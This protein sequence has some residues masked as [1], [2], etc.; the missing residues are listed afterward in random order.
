[1]RC[2]A[3]ALP[4]QFGVQREHASVWHQRVLRIGSIEL[5]AHAAH[6]YRDRR[7]GLRVK[8]ARVH[9][10]ADTFDAKDTR[11]LYRRRVAPS[12]KPLRPIQS[13]CSDPY[14]GPAATRCRNGY[15]LQAKLFRPP[16]FTN[17]PCFQDISR[18]DLSPTFEALRV[19]R[20]NICRITSPMSGG[21]GGRS[22]HAKAVSMGRS[23]C[24]CD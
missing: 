4:W 20:G 18:V 7:S 23:G 2:Y 8:A 19:P 9:D 24:V 5:A 16:R 13:E 1:M 10:F 6:D 17:N 15:V 14:Q 22:P 11:E 3:A 12:R 21:A